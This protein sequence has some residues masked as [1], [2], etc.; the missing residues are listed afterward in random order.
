MDMK[1]KIVKLGPSTMVL[2]LPKKWT[3][4][5]GIKIGD[6]INLVEVNGGLLVEIENKKEGESEK[7]VIGEPHVLIK[8]IIA[9]K[10]MKGCKELEIECES[11]HVSRDIH[12]RVE[13][14]VGFEIVEQSRKKILIKS[15]GVPTEE[16]FDAIFRRVVY[17]TQT[18]SDESVYLCQEKKRDMEYF[19]DMESNLNKLSEFCVRLLNTK[20]HSSQSATASY[21][22]IILFLEEVGDAYKEIVELIAKQKGETNSII[23]KLMKEINK[24]HWLFTK[25]YNQYSTEN[26]IALAVKH[27]QIKKLIDSEL[28]KKHKA[29]DVRI[30]M[31]QKQLVHLLIKMMNELMNLN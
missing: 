30:L 6:E 8:R 17:I 22:A 29:S 7:I 4:K 2:S 21:Y 12:K 9:A 31:E 23:I 10:Y 19:F 1:R 18:M 26:A 28:E 11:Q 27:D 3:E 16:S 14:L 15:I 5:Y 13:G 20:G 24:Y 25:V